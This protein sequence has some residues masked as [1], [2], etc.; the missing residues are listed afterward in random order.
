MLNFTTT[1]SWQPGQPLVSVPVKLVIHALSA[2]FRNLL[3]VAVSVLEPA[4]NRDFMIAEAFSMD[5][6]RWMPS[7]SGSLDAS[8]PA[9]AAGTWACI[10]AP[11]EPTNSAA[12]TMHAKKK[13]EVRTG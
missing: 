3:A 13:I 6:P 9:P 10:D 12:T 7:T 5:I 4:G 1:C 2:V 8:T 11:R